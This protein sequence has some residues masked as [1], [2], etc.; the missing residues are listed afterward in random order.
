MTKPQLVVR[1]DC[2]GNVV[3]V[4]TL[5]PTPTPP[6]SRLLYPAAWLRQAP[7]IQA[8]A[9][10]RFRPFSVEEI[11]ATGQTASTVSFFPAACK[12]NERP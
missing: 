6:D 2:R 3:L 9:P 12:G 11:P 4:Y 1:F 8:G 10:Q 7:S 5:A